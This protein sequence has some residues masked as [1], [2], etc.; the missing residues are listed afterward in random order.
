MR[1]WD[2][3]QVPMHVT[4]SRGSQ[5][6][7]PC[8]LWPVAFLVPYISFVFP[9]IPLF[10]LSS[11]FCSYSLQLSCFDVLAPSHLLLFFLFCCLIS[12][13]CILLLISL[14]SSLDL[15]TLCYLDSVAKAMKAQERQLTIISSILKSGVIKRLS[16]AL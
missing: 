14:P 13:L 16:Q 5:L 3:L 15:H 8:F 6:L 9:E 1:I 7:C 11:S 2:H 4:S 10:L 12:I